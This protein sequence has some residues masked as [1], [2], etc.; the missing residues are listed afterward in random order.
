MLRRQNRDINPFHCAARRTISAHPPQLR[1][2][3]VGAPISDL[4]SSI[5]EQVLGPK[6]TSLTV[7]PWVVFEKKPT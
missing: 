2:S 3:I 1:A 6:I 7:K 5:V 4:Y